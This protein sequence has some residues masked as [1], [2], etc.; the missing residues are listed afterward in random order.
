MKI[1]RIISYIYVI[2][3]PNL[4]LKTFDM[5]TGLK[6]MSFIIA[7][8]TMIIL[9]IF[10]GIVINVSAVNSDGSKS[11]SVMNLI[12]K[13]LY[14]SHHVILLFL[15][16]GMLVT[17]VFVLGSGIPFVFSGLCN[18][19]N[20]ISLYRKKQCSAVKAVVL[21]VMGFVYVLDVIGAVD[22]FCKKER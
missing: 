21:G 5:L 1:L 13:L 18:I 2:L 4:L 17:V 10:S 6:I 7:L 9:G 3:F 16:L 15:S 8:L 11:F 20:C 22:M 19:G 14:L 12:V